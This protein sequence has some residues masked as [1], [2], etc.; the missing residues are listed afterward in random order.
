MIAYTLQEE[1]THRLAQKVIS[2]HA[3]ARRAMRTGILLSALFLVTGC[4][5]MFPTTYPLPYDG[6]R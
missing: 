1:V 2:V 3:K 4:G 6:Q 5:S